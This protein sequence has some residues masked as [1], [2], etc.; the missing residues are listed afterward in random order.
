MVD[1]AQGQP[2]P[3][4][5]LPRAQH[6]LVC[7]PVH[8]NLPLDLTL[9]S[10]NNYASVPN[11][12]EE[13]QNLLWRNC[14]PRK[15]ARGR[16]EKAQAK[17]TFSLERKTRVKRNVP[18]G[19]LFDTGAVDIPMLAAGETVGVL[20]IKPSRLE[21]FLE[22]YPLSPAG[23]TG[24]GKG[25]RRLFS[26]DDIRR[27][28]IAKYLL[29]DRFTPKLVANILERL[30]EEHLIDY[31]QHGEVYRSVVLERDP[32]SGARTCDIIGERVPSGKNVYYRL[33]FS[34]V[35]AEIDRRITAALEKRRK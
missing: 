8:R 13:F 35:T 15:N 4:R 10:K 31:D 11:S 5:D 28:A 24:R 7:P 33:N 34:D 1:M 21:R 12:S 20:G 2:E 17:G 14:L 19:D 16:A 26:P 30:A 23:Q 27:L 3:L 22:N 9:T 32:K 29:D 18:F 25:S 6:S